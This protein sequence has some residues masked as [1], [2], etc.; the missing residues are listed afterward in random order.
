MFAIV[1]LTG[2]GIPASLAQV[3]S[4][5]RITSLQSGETSSGTRVSLFSDSILNDYEAFRRGDRF[6]V[7]IPFAGFDAAQPSLRA[8]A[9]EDIQI[10]RVGDS[11]VVSFKLQPGVS[12]RVD[13][14]SN[15]LDV[16]FTS[17]N[18]ATPV[19]AVNSSPNRSTTAAIPGIVTLQNT[20]NPQLQ[21]NSNLAGPM[22]PDTPG[23][24][25]PRVVD[26]P[27]VAAK[28]SKKSV[29]QERYIQ[30][31]SSQELL[32]RSDTRPGSSATATKTTR[33]TPSADLGNPIA[34]SYSS[35]PVTPSASPTDTAT[36]SATPYSPILSR[37]T[38]M[39]PS[40]SASTWGK[41]LEMV[42][43]WISTNRAP[44]SIGAAVLFGLIIFA[45]AMFYRRRRKPISAR[46]AKVQGVKPRY[47]PGNDFEGF[48]NDFGNEV[49]E[50]VFD[51]YETEARQ[52]TAEVNLPFA[53]DSSP[54][55]Q[56][57]QW[58]DEVPEFPVAQTPPASRPMTSPHVPKAPSIPIHA[59]KHEESEREV[60]EL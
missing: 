58:A 6:Y 4:Q 44:T 41:R 15:R 5:K 29:P 33:S 16:Y 31:A 25:R 8:N 20:R 60:F 11:L 49:Y 21:R 28:P 30:A 14:R 22:P 37:P 51:D 59:M 43:K 7:K 53:D 50:T 46:R 54:S 9:F 12:A 10:Q 26:L 32:S 23:A 56:G 34:Q 24:G 48:E 57:T 52:S 2:S 35:S 18:K 45:L 39:S 38:A 27:P 42:S 40:V 17:P 3:K 13:Q 55:K 36:T 19:S 47:S 1:G